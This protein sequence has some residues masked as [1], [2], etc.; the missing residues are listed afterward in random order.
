MR[1]LLLGFVKKAFA[2]QEGGIIVA[3]VV[4][5]IVIAVVNPAFTSRYNIT[6][7]ILGFSFIS[8][9]AFGE[10][11][12][13]I[14]GEIDLSVGSIA[15]LSGIIAAWLMSFLALPP[16]L[17]IVIGLGTGLGFGFLNGLLVTR[18][19]LNS[20]IAT[21][22]TM[23][24]ISGLI[25]VVTKGRAIVRLPESVFFLGR[26]SLGILPMPVFIMIAVLLY[27]SFML[28]AT[29]FG[30]RVYFIGGNETAAR[31]AGVNVERTKTAVFA[32]SG[33]L[34]ALSGILMMARLTSGQ[35]TIGQYW[36]M[37]SIAAAVIGGTSL[38]GGKGSVVGT[39]AGAA[40]LGILQNAIAILGIS[41]YWER[42]IIGSVVVLA[43][44][45]DVL[46]ERF[47]YLSIVRGTRGVEGERE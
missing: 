47:T 21:L 1:D 30:K 19:G 9:V 31:V 42:T 6:T 23:E 35:P 17:A 13:L 22:G 26:G 29:V 40:I 12:V 3:L 2:S 39:L 25:L 34:S 41:P 11:L 15:G 5:C 43:V 16:F 10:T 4:M 37:P 44:T 32:I 14:A 27:L 46:R 33:F 28:N 36:L 24:A 18:V 7:L 8:I 20:F 45:I 38:T